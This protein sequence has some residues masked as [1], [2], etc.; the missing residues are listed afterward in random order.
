MRLLDVHD[1]RETRC[2]L[3]CDLSDVR[4]EV[5]DG[6]VPQPVPW[7]NTVV[8]E[9]LVGGV[10]DHT[11]GLAL[12]VLLERPQNRNGQ[13]VAPTSLG[14]LQGHPAHQALALVLKELLEKNIWPKTC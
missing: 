8:H 5:A 12:G 10:V 13:G 1:Q 2:L 7:A 11:E 14:F 3:L 4:G 6:G 9:D